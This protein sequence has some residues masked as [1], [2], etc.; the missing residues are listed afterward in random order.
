MQNK[1]NDLEKR[2]SLFP[3]GVY[4]GLLMLAYV[5]VG[6]NTYRLQPVLTTL[7]DYL[8]FCAP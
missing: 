8:S 3:D 4:L 1:R 7:M 2:A 6:I 5:I